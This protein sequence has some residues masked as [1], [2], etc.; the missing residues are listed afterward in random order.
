MD[1][2]TEAQ[3]VLTPIDYKL[4]PQ[5]CTLYLLTDGTQVGADFEVHQEAQDTAG[6]KEPFCFKDV[7]L[8]LLPTASPVP[9]KSP[10]LKVNVTTRQHFFDDVAAMECTA[11]SSFRRALLRRAWLTDST[12]YPSGSTKFMPRSY[13]P[14]LLPAND[15]ASEAPLLPNLE[16]LFQLT[17]AG[18]LP[19]SMAKTFLERCCCPRLFLSYPPVPF[20]CQR[21]QTS[22][23]IWTV[24]CLPPFPFVLHRHK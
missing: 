1:G 23:T 13:L 4:D 24:S 16:S 22:L 12:S 19:L 5:G 15:S 3:R 17:V 10:C 20:S 21:Y 7:K 8:A 14:G 18:E 2:E 9:F 6:K 11:Q